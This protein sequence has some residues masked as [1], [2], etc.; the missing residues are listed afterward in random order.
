MENILLRRLV[1]TNTLILIC[2]IFTVATLLDLVS[3][4]TLVRDVGTNYAHLGARLILC[5]FASLSLF[6]F[7]YFKKLSIALKIGIHFVVLLL[8]TALYVWISGLFIEQH[9]RAMFYML[10][11]VLIV[12]PLVVIGCIIVDRILKAW[13]NRRPKNSKPTP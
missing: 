12:Y 1:Y 5:T 6:V 10:R 7:R 2:V 3:T 4:V 8:F 9:P 11:S 13:R